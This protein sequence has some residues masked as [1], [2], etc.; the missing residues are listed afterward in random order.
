VIWNREIWSASQG[1]PRP[2]GGASPHTNHIHVFFTEAHADEEPVWLL[3]QLD[4]LAV[5]R[6][7][8]AYA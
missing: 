2:Y 8:S 6:A 3:P 7:G 5:R 4:R 1:G